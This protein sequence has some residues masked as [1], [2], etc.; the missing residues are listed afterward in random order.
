VNL[1]MMPPRVPITDA[2][3][4]ITREWYRFLAA[5]YADSPSTLAMS[6][7]PTQLVAALL[8]GAVGTLYTAPAGTRARIDAAVFV[9]P[10][11]GALTVS[12]WLVPPGQSASASNIVLSAVSIAAGATRVAPEL[13]GQVLLSGG[14]LQALGAGLSLVASGVEIT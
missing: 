13:V 7:T 2:S 8:P 6:Q 5:L 1:Q 4:L 3:G 12:A 11:G 10:T 14:T 9:N